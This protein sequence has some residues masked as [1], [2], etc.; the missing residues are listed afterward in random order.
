MIAAAIT[1]STAM[2]EASATPYRYVSP[3]ANRP[4]KEITTVI[5]ATST[6]RPA[7]PTASPIASD[8]EAP[9]A[10]AAR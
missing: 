9:S 8:P 5:P 1:T 6:L 3:I 10:S 7:V 4:N 2:I